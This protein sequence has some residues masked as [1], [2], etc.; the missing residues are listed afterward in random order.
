MRDF[1]INKVV[2]GVLV[3]TI[4]GAFGAWGSNS[5]Q[6][7]ANKTSIQTLTEDIKKIE[8]NHTKRLERLESSRENMSNFYVT[9]AEFNVIVQA[10]NEKIN[11]ID[12]NIEKLLDIQMNKKD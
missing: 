4:L 7:E 9:R 8:N 11:K 6:I 3:A 1:V 2:P 10:Q 5:K 12:R